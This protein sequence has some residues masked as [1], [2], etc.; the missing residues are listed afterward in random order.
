MSTDGQVFVKWLSH[1]SSNLD[2]DGQA[3]IEEVLYL[4]GAQGLTQK[5]GEISV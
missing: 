2:G 4:R 5:P 1:F 3:E